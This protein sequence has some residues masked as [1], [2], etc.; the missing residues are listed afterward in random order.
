MLCVDVCWKTTRSRS[1]LRQQL[2]VYPLIAVYYGIANISYILPNWEKVKND[3]YSLV[4]PT[5]ALHIAHTTNFLF[6]PH[7]CLSK[8][9]AV[10]PKIAS[11]RVI[12]SLNK[13][14]TTHNINITFAILTEGCTWEE[15]AK[16]WNFQ[17][18]CHIIGLVIGHM[19][20]VCQ[21]EDNVMLTSYLIHTC[22]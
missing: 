12:W 17:A 10:K 22:N 18:M 20:N 9:Q 8:S 15:L 19:I 13:D 7:R 3:K 21:R 5:Q 4:H 1:R 14:Y 11:H 2:H 6:F 16:N